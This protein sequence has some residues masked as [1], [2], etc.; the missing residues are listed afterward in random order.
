MK[1]RLDVLV[2]GRGFAPSREKAKAMI[3][4][5]NVFINNRCRIYCNKCIEIGDKTVIGE[6]VLIRDNDGHFMFAFF[7][8]TFAVAR[9]VRTRAV[10]EYS[11]TSVMFPIPS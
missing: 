4:E 8:I 7:R 5:G 6:D 9:N 11:L 3:M 10:Y 1:E 2:V